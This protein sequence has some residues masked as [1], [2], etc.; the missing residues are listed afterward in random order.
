M[1]IWACC[2]VMVCACG[3]A[4]DETGCPLEP[5]DAIGARCSNDGV[6]CYETSLCDP[7]TSDMASCEAIT[8]TDGRWAEL[9]LPTT[10]DDTSG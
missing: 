2:F 6:Q 4:L 5:I 9:A 3:P 8:C 10:C 1:R 7:C